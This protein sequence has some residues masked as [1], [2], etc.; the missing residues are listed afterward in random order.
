M[1]LFKRTSNTETVEE[2]F[3]VN[4]DETDNDRIKGWAKSLISAKASITLLI[5][6]ESNQETINA[7]LYRPDVR[8]AGEH[9]TGF[10]GFNFDISDWEDKDIDI[11]P[12]GIVSEN[13]RSRAKYPLFFIHIPKTAGTSFK[14]AAEQYFGKDAVVKNYGKD[15]VETTAWIDENMNQPTSLPMLYQRLKDEGAA[16][17]TGH[18]HA[19]PNLN[20]F[21]AMQTMAFLRNPVDQVVSHYNHYTRW[22]EYSGSIEKFSANPGFKNLQS[23]YLQGLPLFITGFV[24]ITEHYDLSLRMINQSFGFALRKLNANVNDQRGVTNVSAELRTHIESNNQKDIQLYEQGCDLLEQR[25][26]MVNDKKEWCYGAVI[27][28]DKG[29]VY[30]IAYYQETNEHVRL[31]VYY[32]DERLGGCV[33]NEFRPRFLVHN[34]PNHCYVGFK[35][36]LPKKCDP[37][38]LTVKVDETGQE[39]FFDF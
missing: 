37:L 5:R 35:Y 39:M 27:G 2:K 24:G 10:C 11:L 16:I 26:R 7:D 3:C 14:K 22:Y 12:V 6:S 18:I 31:S 1:R 32:K 13:I 23:R 29:V 34:L 30:G 21:P 9:E 25:A 19:K 8:R 36:K 38:Y 20:V 4:V 17:Y 33:A 15:S 28:I